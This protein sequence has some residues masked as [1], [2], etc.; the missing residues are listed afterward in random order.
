[1]GSKLTRN[2]HDAVEIAKEVLQENYPDAELNNRI[3]ETDFHVGVNAG[4]TGLYIKNGSSQVTDSDIEEIVKRVNEEVE[5]DWD[6][7]NM[8]Y[9]GG[10][11]TFAFV[12][13]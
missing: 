1:M 4:I 9:S 13:N 11:A 10:M 5:N 6:F 2:V 3:G 12:E 7:E 8:G